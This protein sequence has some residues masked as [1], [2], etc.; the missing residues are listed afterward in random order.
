MRRP[1]KP[2]IQKPHLKWI[3]R[4]AQN[5]W[6]PNHLTTWTEGGKRKSRQ[7]KL[8]WKGDPQ[9]LDRLYWQ[10]QAGQHQRQATPARYTWRECIIEWRR[11]PIVQQKIAASTKASYRPVMDEI[12]QKNGDKDMRRTT[13]KAVRAAIGKLAETPR[14]ASRYAQ[15]I[16]LL[17]NYATRELDWPLGQ[18]PAAGLAKHKPARE[19]EPW[20]QWMVDKLPSAPE[21]VETAA[22]L[23]LGT[24]QRP[25]AAISMTKAAFSGEW[26][27]VRDEK[28]GDEFDVFCPPLL[29]EY[30]DRLPN[31][32]RYIL[33]KNL[34]EPLGYG[35]VE[36]QFRKWRESLGARAK[37]YTLHG[38]R[39]L[40]IIQ[41][42][43][44]GCG[45]AE[46]QAVT[47]QSAQMVAY[48]RAKANRKRLSKSAQ[49]SRT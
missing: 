9:E 28:A 2:R 35:A 32:G 24:G 16:S 34:T 3:W 5:A 12:M 33:A 13:R 42:A 30:I 47:G 31:R 29:R 15:T 44:A 46:I 18:N 21:T 39:K 37:P 40:A 17:H 38:L 19:F 43:E 22:M 4:A 1:P 49:E 26:M 23:I 27:R 20:P 14:K 36:K 8:D 10:C 25:N 41:L 11:D 6:E 48:Y 45:D 7:I